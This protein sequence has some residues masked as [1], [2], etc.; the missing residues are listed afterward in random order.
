[1]YMYVE[2]KHRQ[3]KRKGKVDQDMG[4]HRGGK[5][6]HCPPPPLEIQKYGAPT[7]IT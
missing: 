4:A 5:K 7:R 6:G 2:N 3:T 1:M